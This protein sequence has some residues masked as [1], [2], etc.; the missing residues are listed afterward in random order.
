MLSGVWIE[1]FFYSSSW[2]GA[3]SSPASMDNSN[4]ASSI[5]FGPNFI[6]PGDDVSDRSIA[7]SVRCLL[8]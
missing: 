6:H 7:L 1:N 3:W 5:D 8:N 4:H 2:S